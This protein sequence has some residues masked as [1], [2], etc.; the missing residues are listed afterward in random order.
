VKLRFICSLTIIVLLLLAGSD[1]AMAHGISDEDKRAMLEG[2]YLRYVG[3]GASHMLT[4]YDHLLFLFGVMFFLT[5]LSEV[6]KFISAFTLGH[7]I[8]LIGATFMGV[9]ANYFLVDALIALTVFYKGFDNVDGFKKYLG[10]DSPNLLRLVFVF[11][12]IH[13]FGLS[14]RLQQLPLGDDS[15]RLFLQILSFNVGVEVGQVLALSAML[16][17][18]FVWRKRE[19]FAR[20]SGTANVG[21][22]IAGVLLFLMQMHGF[23]HESF[24]NDLAFSQDS[25]RLAHSKMDPTK[26]KPSSKETTQWSAPITI[27]IPAGG[28]LEYKLYLLKGAV[29]QYAWATD[30]G[31]LEFDFHGEPTGAKAGVFESFEKDTASKSSG[32]FRSPFAGTVGWWWKN[33]SMLP[34]VVTLRVKGSYRIVGPNR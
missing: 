9:T 16:L 15:L 13:G 27:T 30:K 11:G 29:V 12:L 1:L 21:L 24:V 18:L 34:V 19:S 6:V 28:G 20:F 32:S 8:T 14:T 23:T 31:D 7:C 4:G 2:G 5:S 22:M 17:V 3:L 25:H 33:S 10:M 26:T